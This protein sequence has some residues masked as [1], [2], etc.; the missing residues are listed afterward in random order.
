MSWPGRRGAH[1]SPADEAT[2][3][4]RE[5]RD[6]VVTAALRAQRLR[7]GAVVAL[8]D[9]S[10]LDQPS[11]EPVL[12]AARAAAKSDPTQTRFRASVPIVL[13]AMSVGTLLI[14]L[15]YAGGRSHQDWGPVLFWAGWTISFLP[16]AVAVTSPSLSGRARLLVVL[17]QAAQQSLVRWMY[18]PL[19][20]TFPDELQHWRTAVDILTFHH[21]YH[22]NPTLPVSPVFPGLEELATSLVSLSHIGLFPAGLI[23]SATS[24]VAQSA[25]LFYLYRRISG[26]DRVAGVATFLF[27]LTPLH[28]GFD[29]MFIY[30]AP[31]L[32]FGVVVVEIAV[33]SGNR[34]AGEL[35]IA[36]TS[37]A[38][39]IVTHHLTAAIIIA[40]LGVTGV[41]LAI[42]TRLGPEARRSLWLCVVGA[43]LAV[44]WITLA[45][46]S[47]L[48]YL[49]EPLELVIHG[50]LHPG[51][52]AGTVPFP[53]AAGGQIQLEVV[54]V[55]I[56]SALVVA[57]VLL[58]WLPRFRD[59]H[60]PLARTFA[61][62]APVYFAILV[63]RVFAPDGGELAGRLLTYVSLFTA[64]TMAFPLVHTWNAP[65]RF[66]R[67]MRPLAVT[68]MF[69][70]FLSGMMG[71]WPAPW[72]LLPG[73]FHAAAYESG[74][75]RQN[76]VAAQ[77]FGS[78]APPNSR[79]ACDLSSCSLLG[80]YSEAHPIYDAGSIYYAPH[81]DRQVLETI[82]R[83]D[84]QYLF[85]DL[86]M[87]QEVP[88]NGSFFHLSD[89]QAADQARA[90][91]MTALTKFRGA[92]GMQLIYNS[93]V[94]QI[95]DL[96]ALDHA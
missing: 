20:F 49:G 50:V 85:V 73:T 11:S 29:T 18:S 37:M 8:R 54:G 28:A 60:R 80:A 92:R 23:V 15:G 5:G 6:A 81:V 26:S 33:S 86:R 82:H 35:V 34:V 58:L 71:G 31:A 36:V 32:L 38:A 91:P 39:L 56:T 10:D 83:R 72:E 40:T 66:R 94:I 70:L 55:A 77:W 78:H 4:P 57:G 69:G 2:N 89:T 93:G 61:L 53:R 41:I 64:I 51:H 45:A 14:A 9:R 79:I 44:G 17:L 13:A 48:S 74:V 22:F 75:D 3:G 42:L 46:G 12:P 96:Q 90:I 47:A 43:A 84:I 68:A 67:L 87:S 30:T 65:A 95:Y 24:H 62:C 88:V 76:I 1:R 63:I 27:A 59:S 52:S 25:A 16:L 19:S 7:P 21:L